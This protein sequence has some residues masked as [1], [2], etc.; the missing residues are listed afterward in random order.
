MSNTP[1]VP[2]DD[3]HL[4]QYAANAARELKLEGTVSCR[5]L[6]RGLKAGLKRVRRAQE[7]LNLWSA[8]QTTV[9]GAVEW[10]LDNHYLAVREGEQ[11]REAFKGGKPLRGSRGAMCSS[12]G[13]PGAPC[14]PP[15]TWTRS[16]WPSFWRAFSRCAP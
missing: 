2:M 10:L 4:K 14:G 9:P 15:P 16:G 6:S 7:V 3:A 11:A 12:G 1:H 5:A 8:G 13:A